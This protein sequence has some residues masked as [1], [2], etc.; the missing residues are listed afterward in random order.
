MPGT[1]F[2]SYS[3]KNEDWKERVVTHL[4]VLAMDEESQIETWDD[5][6]IEAGEEWYEAI[7]QAIETGSIAVLLVS[8]DSL[9]SK[10]IM[11][12]EIPRLL[13]LRESGK[14]R[15]LIP[16]II[17]HCAW[18]KVEW[19]S[20]LQARPK[21]GEPLASMTESK[22]DEALAKLAAEIEQMMSK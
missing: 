10:F 13:A 3:H 20:K 17:K 11:K 12:E 9:T 21:D 14:L 19:L 4:N 7:A 16:L 8:A 15:R 2:I 18:Q 5:R 1:I 22:A 6:R